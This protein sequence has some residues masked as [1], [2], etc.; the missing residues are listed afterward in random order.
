MAVGNEHGAVDLLALARRITDD[1]VVTF[2]YMP[3]DAIAFVLKHVDGTRDPMPTAYDHYV[4]MELA[5]GEAAAA[6][7]RAMLE[8]VL[9]EGLEDGIVLDAVFAES[10]QQAADFWKIRE[11]IPEAQKY[12]GASSKHDISVPVSRVA[13]FLVEAIADL[14]KMVPG[15]R[16]C[17][18]GHVG[19]GNIHFNLSRPADMSDGD[20]RAMEPEIHKAVYDRTVSMGGSISAEHGIGRL[21]RGE[22]DTYKSPVALDVMRSIKATLDP[23]GIMNPGKVL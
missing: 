19:D 1:R 14:E 3:R 13:D 4:L 18:F 2:E 6:E 12:E 9:G 20:F 7:L 5:A 21:R 17:A 16:P 15:I 22:L 23:N 8:E 10:G 11:T